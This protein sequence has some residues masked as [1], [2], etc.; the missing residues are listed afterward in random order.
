MFATLEGGK[1]AS[2]AIYVFFE[3]NTNLDTPNN[4]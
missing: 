4:I 3:Q 2:S 1:T